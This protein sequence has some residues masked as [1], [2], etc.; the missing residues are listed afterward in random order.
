MIF[1]VLGVNLLSIKGMKNASTHK[2]RAKMSTQNWKSFYHKKT[3][4]INTLNEGEGS[5]EDHLR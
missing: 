1:Y 3:I 4:S 2:M 5:G